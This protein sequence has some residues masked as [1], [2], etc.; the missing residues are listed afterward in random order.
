[1]I[2]RITQ[3][4]TVGEIAIRLGQPVHRVDYAIRSR[5]IRPAARAGRLRVFSTEAIAQIQ[6]A[7]DEADRREV[8][9]G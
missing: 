9:N 5:G 7:I 3:L 1:M 2:Q 6:D 4:L 8:A